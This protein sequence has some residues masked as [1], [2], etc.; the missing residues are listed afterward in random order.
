MLRKISEAGPEIPTFLPNLW[1]EQARLKLD[2][3]GKRRVKGVGEV[4]V[5][6]K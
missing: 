5:A 1:R 2:E 3:T 6:L 4:G